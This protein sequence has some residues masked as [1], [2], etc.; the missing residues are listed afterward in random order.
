MGDSE[1]SFVSSVLLKEGKRIDLSKNEKNL[2]KSQIMLWGSV[3]EGGLPNNPHR[4]IIREDSMGS[5]DVSSFSSDSNDSSY[6]PRR[7]SHLSDI[8]PYLDE[9]T[10]D[11]VFYQEEDE[12]TFESVSLLAQKLEKEINNLFQRQSPTVL[13]GLISTTKQV[14]SHLIELSE[15]EPYGVKGARVILKF[16]TSNGEEQTMGSFLLD[17]N[18]MSTFE[19]TLVLQQ[20]QQFSTALR[21]WF[22][23]I[24]NGTKSVQVGPHYSLR[25]KGLYTSAKES[26]TFHSTS[27]KSKITK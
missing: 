22:G 19:I 3:K 10:R 11:A 25:K 23:Q 4:K 16:R 21:S 20:S 13:V 18:T 12:S 14:A 27:F 17:P 6:G 7:T 24:T 9:E 8:F 5:L 1:L 2:V 26:V 15:N